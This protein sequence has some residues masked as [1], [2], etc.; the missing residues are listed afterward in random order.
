[1]N[2]MDFFDRQELARK[3]SKI[4]II[5]YVLAVIGITCTFGFA[6]LG[7]RALLILKNSSSHSL[8]LYGFFAREEFLIFS[9]SVLVLILLST[10]FKGISLSKGGEVVARSLGG[11]EVDPSTGNASERMLINVVEEMSIASGVPVPSIYILDQEDG[12]NAF[13]A[14]HSPSNATIG[15]TSGCLRSF[16]RDELQGVIAHEFSHI[17]NGDMR[18][19]IRMMSVLFGILMMTILGRGVLRAFA[20]SSGSS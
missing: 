7:V 8:Q 13:A 2:G 3:N 10:F 6:A 17:L 11:R 20:N 14:G 18:L 19:N 1:M 4:L 9:G 15:V 5:Y 16:N 12:I